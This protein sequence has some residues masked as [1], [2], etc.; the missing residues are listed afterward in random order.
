V[1]EKDAGH[2]LLRWL[3]LEDING[4]RWYLQS[5]WGILN[6]IFFF[7]VTHYL[8]ISIPLF[9]SGLSRQITVS[10]AVIS[11]YAE[12]LLAPEGEMVVI[13]L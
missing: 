9:F 4:H 7:Q 3:G 8:S 5:T 11:F 12:H 1:V 13:F 10:L 2:G 6:A